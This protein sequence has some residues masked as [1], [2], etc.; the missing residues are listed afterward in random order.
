MLVIGNGAKV[1]AVD[2]NG[3]TSLQIALQ[4]GKLKT[5]ELLLTNG[6]DFKVSNGCGETV[7]HLLCK[8]CVDGNELCEDLISHGV[9]PHLADQEGNLPLYIALKNELPKTSCL[10]FKQLGSFTLDDLQKVNT[11]NRSALLCS[12]VNSCDTENCRK[13]LDID[14]NPNTPNTIDLDLL[15][16]LELPDV[17]SIHPLHIAVAKNNSELC[18]LLLD[19]GANVNVQMRTHCIASRFHL[20]QPLHLAV[21]LGFI[22]VCRLLIERDALIDAET[23]KGKSPLHLAIV[24]NRN[25][26]ARLLLSYNA[27]LD[28]TL[29]RSARRGTQSVAQLLRDSGERN[30][31]VQL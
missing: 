24:G 11:Q 8:G 7:L 3:G 23:E 14:V 9:S 29:E 5:A 18:H 30:D 25:D 15:P 21:E 13:L 10:L 19:H 26:I 20:A 6:A 2:D 4:S 22:N 28:F 1:N 27:V 17:A 12:A 31:T 16:D